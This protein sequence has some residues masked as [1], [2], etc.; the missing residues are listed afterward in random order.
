MA[1]PAAPHQPQATISLGSARARRRYLGLGTSS[2]ERRDAPKRAPT[3]QR[4]VAVSLPRN[5][6]RRRLP[7][8][9]STSPATSSPTSPP[10]TLLTAALPTTPSAS[11]LASPASL[12][13]SFSFP[14]PRSFLSYDLLGPCFSPS[15]AACLDCSVSLPSSHLQHLVISATTTFRHTLSKARKQHCLLQLDYAVA[16]GYLYLVEPRRV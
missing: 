4:L 14:S 9:P 3:A 2:P 8:L 13:F 7:T 15:H 1:L 5:H 12:S 6:P 10:P 11:S 16:F